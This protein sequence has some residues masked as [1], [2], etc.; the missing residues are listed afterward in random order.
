MADGYAR[1]GGRPGV[2]MVVP[3]VGVYNAASGLATAYACSSP[4]LLVA[5]QVNRHG[6]GRD[7]G[8]LHDIH[9]QLDIVRPDHQVGRARHRGRRDRRRRARGVRPDDIRDGRGRPRSRSRRRRSPSRPAPAARPRPR[10]EPVV[11]AEADLDEGRRSCSPR[12]RRPLIIAGGGVVLGDA[13]GGA[14]ARRRAAA[15]AGRHHPRGQGRDRRPAS[16]VGRH[17]VGQPAA[18]A[19]PRRRRRRAGGRQPDAGLRACSPAS[20]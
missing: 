13:G 18:A 19:G 16:A 1:A 11:P 17:D 9:D 12:R 3:G 8:L 6:I 10:A 2:A 4:V 20:S 15:G 7:L 14:H 5:G